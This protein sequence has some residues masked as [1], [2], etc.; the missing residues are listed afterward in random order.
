[1]LCALGEILSLGGNIREQLV[2]YN[3]F[4]SAL[5][6]CDS[7]NLLA[8]DLSGDIVG[9]DLDYVVVAL[10]LALEYLKSFRLV[11][12][13]DNSV[14]N[15]SVDYS[16]SRNVADIGQRD[17]ITVAA[18]SVGAPGSC[19]SACKRGKLTEIVD[20]VDLCEG[21]GQRETDSGACRRN[22]LEACGGRVAG[23]CL[24]FLYKL[25]AVECVEE[26]N[27][28]GTSVQNLDGKLSAVFHVN[29][30]GFL[31]RVAAVL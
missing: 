9:V 21:I 25:P 1:M 29:S 23:S 13:S 7:V 20:P 19:V 16:C 30:G 6:E 18:H 27:V 31:I 12:G 17:E 2:V 28:A 5:L 22:M 4:V 3:E 24:E 8:L 26:I 14:R 11:T 15:L 10:F